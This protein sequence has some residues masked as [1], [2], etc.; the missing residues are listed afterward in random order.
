VI[1]N[2]MSCM[3]LLMVPE[4]ETANFVHIASFIVFLFFSQVFLFIV[5]W[6]FLVFWSLSRIF[7]LMKMLVVYSYTFSLNEKKSLHSVFT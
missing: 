1:N 4:Q 6:S 5:F 3:L 2:L 7:S